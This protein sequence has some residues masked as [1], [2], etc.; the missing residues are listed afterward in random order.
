MVEIILAV[1]LELGADHQLNLFPILMILLENYV[2]RK[3][4]LEE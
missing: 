2:S 4:G 3:P 1:S